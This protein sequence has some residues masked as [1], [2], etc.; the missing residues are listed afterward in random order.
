MQI[1]APNI[2]FAGLSTSASLPVPG[3]LYLV[4]EWDDA[5]AIVVVIVV[6]KNDVAFRYLDGAL[7]IVSVEYF[8]HGLHAMRFAEA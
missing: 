7:Q 5:I 3:K 6:E 1:P 8:A 2:A 4:R